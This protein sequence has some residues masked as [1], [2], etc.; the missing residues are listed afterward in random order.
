MASRP[1][2]AA[3]APTGEFS[4]AIDALS[5]CRPVAQHWPSSDAFVF[6]RSTL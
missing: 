4:V 1:A 2:A 5:D 6:R 3:E